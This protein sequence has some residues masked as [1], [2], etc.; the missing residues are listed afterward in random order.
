MLSLRS[1][2]LR[3]SFLGTTSALN[4]ED[5][6]T[7]IRHVIVREEAKPRAR[8]L[9]Q[10][11]IDFSAMDTSIA[12]ATRAKLM[13]WIFSAL[14]QQSHHHQLFS[15]SQTSRSEISRSKKSL[16]GLEQGGGLLTNPRPSQGATY[17]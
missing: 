14:F 8:K 6:E 16:G 4:T 12:S 10:T 15:S 13:M 1:F 17:P 9:T 2:H 11:S 3:S 7:T 5:S